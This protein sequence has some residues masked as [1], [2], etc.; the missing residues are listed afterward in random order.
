MIYEIYYFFIKR[1]TDRNLISNILSMQHKQQ[2]HWNHL[3]YKLKMKQVT[4]EK[5]SQN[6]PTLQ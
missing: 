2:R 1:P 4:E 6:H 3:K 5:K